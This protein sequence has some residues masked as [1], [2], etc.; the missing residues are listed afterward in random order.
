MGNL[1]PD[2]ALI[3]EHVNGIV[4]ARYRDPPYNKIP[5]WE[6]GKNTPVNDLNYSE[7]IDLKKLAENNSAIKLQLDK[8]LNLYYLVKE[9]KQQ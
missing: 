9:E 7:W 5:R 6:I 3:Y 2:E 8:L 1:I 4:Y